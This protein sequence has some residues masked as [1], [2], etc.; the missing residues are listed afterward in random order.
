MEDVPALCDA[1]ETAAFAEVR[2]ADRAL[3]ALHIGLVVDY[4]QYSL[5]AVDLLRWPAGNSLRDQNKHTADGNPHDGI[6]IQEIVHIRI[7][8]LQPCLLLGVDYEL[9]RVLGFELR[10]CD[11]L[12]SEDGDEDSEEEEES[13]DHSMVKIIKFPQD[14]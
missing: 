8:A 13:E 11:G 7:G 12:N 9:I 10:M 14:E 5:E 2:Q 3:P 1:R 6:H 4:L